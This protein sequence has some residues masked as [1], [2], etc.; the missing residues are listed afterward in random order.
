MTDWAA[1]V[2]L[3][4]GVESK[5]RLRDALEPAER[6][7]LA[8]AM[9]ARVMTCLSK[10]DAINS[11]YLLA[12]T[13]VPEWPSHWLPDSGR[14]LNPELE[15]ARAQLGNRPLLVIHADLPHLTV[16]DVQAL[17]AAADECGCAFAPD[18]H[19]RGTNAVAIRD[20]NPFRFAFG[21]DSLMSHRQQ[22]P[23]AAI[24]ERA[25]LGFDIDT[26]ADL[27]GLHEMFSARQD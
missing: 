7:A 24:V 12:P 26:P 2:P 4:Q 6:M 27:A 8:S 19:G 23:A 5:S 18:R 22:R 20:A 15:G 14:G 25:A 21:Q 9:A 10:A 13:V 16:E 3:K 1:L 11:L 17:L